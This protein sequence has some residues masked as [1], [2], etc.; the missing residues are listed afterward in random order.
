MLSEKEFFEKQGANYEKFHASSIELESS[1]VYDLFS[2][3]LKLL[4]ILEKN[5]G[6]EWK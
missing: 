4:D 5:V 2:K 1:H 3:L 6:P